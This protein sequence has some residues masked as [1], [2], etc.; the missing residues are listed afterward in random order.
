M[1]INLDTP[2]MA[3]NFD[4]GEYQAMLG[5]LQANILRAHGRN[6]ARHIFLRFTA[7]QLP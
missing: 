6:F 4:S 1:S 3:V 2:A 7:P 5:K